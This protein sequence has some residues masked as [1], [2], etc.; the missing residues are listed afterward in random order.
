MLVAALV[1]V[2]ACASTAPTNSPSP[3]RGPVTTLAEAWAAVLAF[4]PRFSSITAKDPNLIGQSAW[5]D[6]Q[7]ASGVGAFVVMVQ[8]G[9]GDCPAGCID[10]HTWT[11]A[12]APDG[13]V[14][15]I[16]DEGPVVPVEQL[17]A[18]AIAMG[19]SIRA[20]AGPICPVETDPPDASC[21]PRPVTGARIVVKDGAGSIVGDGPTG[22]LGILDLALPAGG[23][24]IEAAPVDG[25]MGTPEVASATVAD[26]RLTAVDLGYDTGIR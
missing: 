15:V 23:Y 26:G 4:E 16:S 19:L 5:F 13:A 20:T 10:R 9:W 17:P 14:S 7:P 21:A 12:V 18:S 2:T 6:V 24:T 22:L 25:L 1:L 11:L 3:S 8:I